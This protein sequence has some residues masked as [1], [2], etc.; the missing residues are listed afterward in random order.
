M[1]NEQAI[2]QL[3][4]LLREVKDD[5]SEI[6]V[7][8]AAILERCHERR[9][10]VCRIETR[11]DKIEN[12]VEQVEQIV[13]RAVGAKAVIAGLAGLAGAIVIEGVLL[14]IRKVGA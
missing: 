12:K 3:Y 2:K 1:D 9:E 6:K 11:M 10:L 13:Q 7:N 4:D 5:I 14:A 8:Q